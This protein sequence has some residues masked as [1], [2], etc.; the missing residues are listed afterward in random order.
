MKPAAAFCAVIACP[1]F[2]SRSQAPGTTVRII[3]NT[4]Q[5]RSAQ[6]PS[7]RF[8]AAPEAQSAAGCTVV[9]YVGPAPVSGAQGGAAVRV[10]GRSAWT[11]E[12][13]RHHRPAPV[14]KERDWGR[15]AP[16]FA[17]EFGHWAA[18][19]SRDF[20]FCGLIFFFLISPPSS[21]PFILSPHSP[22]LLLPHSP[23]PFL[24]HPKQKHRVARVLPLSYY[25]SPGPRLVV[26]GT[27]LC[28]SPLHFF[29]L[30]L[31][32]VLPHL[33]DDDDDDLLRHS[34]VTTTTGS[35]ASGTLRDEYSEI[36]LVWLS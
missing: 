5:C 36:A 27:E 31:G 2:P 6:L 13:C 10:G 14:E 23:L 24:Q 4:V 7:N 30:P 25:A 18:A 15:W 34:F 26:E 8:A 35:R 9:G 17:G 32:V 11:C 33:D 12:N 19:G 3:Q 29:F 16:G 20:S 28:F 21:T 22:S 1:A